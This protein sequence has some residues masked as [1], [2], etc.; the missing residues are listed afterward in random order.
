MQ[1]ISP[2]CHKI[3]NGAH[4]KVS[5]DIMFQSSFTTKN[6]I[7]SPLNFNIVNFI[8]FFSMITKDIFTRFLELWKNAPLMLF[9]PWS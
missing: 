1:G 8:T 9:F 6:L 2:H 7:S 4:Y 5:N 3:M